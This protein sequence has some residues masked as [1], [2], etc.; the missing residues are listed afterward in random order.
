MANTVVPSYVP[1]KNLQN[2]PTY[3]LQTDSRWKN[4]PYTVSNQKNQTI[5]YSGCGPTCA[6][7]IINQWIDRS[8]SPIE[9]CDWAKKSGYRTANSGTAWGMFK[10]V[11]VKY[12]LQFKQTAYFDTAKKWISE[13]ENALV[14][15]IM[16]KGI[17]TSGGHYILMYRTDNGIVYIN[18]P[19]STV[20]NK[21]V[22]QSKYLS[23]QCRQYFCFA[24]SKEQAS[25]WAKKVEQEI[26][27]TRMAVSSQSVYARKQ[28]TTSQ[29]DNVIGMFL[30]GALVKATK[31]SGDWFY[32]TGTGHR[33]TTVN[34]WCPSNCLERATLDN[35]ESDIATLTRE[36]L[37]YLVD[38]KF[39]DTPDYWVD[40]IFDVDYITN[41]FIAVYNRCMEED[42]KSIPSDA[43]KFTD[44][45]KA[46]DFM[47]KIGIINS[48]DYW[49]ANM[50]KVKYLDSLLCKV[51]T[52]LS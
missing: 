29:G 52:W 12:G 25:S 34:G 6:A 45:N 18:D 43:T 49:R 23:A 32:V 21:Q 2:R 10:A 27:P 36:A 42:I 15:C 30:E 26:I 44:P 31:K 8:I 1:M 48:P 46:L 40:H 50:S 51:A 24:A 13:H 38:I 33:N 14:V 9:M 22:N 7:M 47:V 37:D 19:N 4:I 5:G 17:W 11:A 35:V 20:E 28:P 16:S 3:F 39:I 41:I